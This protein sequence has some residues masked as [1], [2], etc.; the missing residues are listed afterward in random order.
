MHVDGFR[1]DLASVLGRDEKGT[2]LANPPLLRRIE[3]DP[4][5]RD[6][7]IIA[8]AWY[9]ACAFWGVIPAQ[10]GT[11]KGSSCMFPVTALLLSAVAEGLSKI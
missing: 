4:V 8:E 7:K 5:L 6:T 9:A 2:L 3:E 10:S 11:G 1:F